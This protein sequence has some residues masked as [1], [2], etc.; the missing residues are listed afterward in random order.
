MLIS[1]I[2][3]QINLLEEFL[4]DFPHPNTTEQDQSIPLPLSTPQVDTSTPIVSSSPETVLPST[5]CQ[6]PFYQTASKTDSSLPF[7]STNTTEGSEIGLEY[8]QPSNI[9]NQIGCGGDSASNFDSA[10][11]ER[12]ERKIKSRGGKKSSTSSSALNCPYCN[13][14]FRYQRNY[15]K[16]VDLC[17]NKAACIYCAQV[18]KSEVKRNEHQSNCPAVTC[19][20]CGHISLSKDNHLHHVKAHDRVTF[21]CRTC[22][23][24]FYSKKELVKHQGLQHGWG[25]KK[26][27]FPWENEAPWLNEGGY[28]DKALEIAI[29]ASKSHILAP[30]SLGD[31][32]SIYNFPTNNLKG[33]MNEFSKEISEIYQDQKHSFRINIAFG[34]IIQNVE[35]GDYRYFIPYKNSTIFDYPMRVDNHKD[36]QKVKE[37]IG[38]IDLDDYF[39]TNRPNTKWKGVMIV[40]TTFFITKSNYV[41]GKGFLPD[42]IKRKKSITGLDSERGSRAPIKDKLCAFRCIA[43]FLGSQHVT[44]AAIKYYHKFREY[45]LNVLGKRISSNHSLFQGISMIDLPELERCFEICI[46]VYELQPDDTV[47]LRYKPSTNFSRVMHLNMYENHLSYINNFSS[48]AKKFSCPTCVRIFD[49]ISNYKSHLL[50]CGMRT[51]YKFKGGYYSPTLTIFE[52]LE[53]NGI[54]VPENM[55]LFEYF[56]VFDIESVLEKVDSGNAEKL[57]WA[58]RHSAISVSICSN[59]PGYDHPKC[60]I[61]PD[62]KKL[63]FKMLSYLDTVQLEVK[64]IHLERFEEYI[65]Q[66]EQ[67]RDKYLEE[68]MNESWFPKSPTLSNSSPQL[69]NEHLCECEGEDSGDESG[70][71]CDNN[72]ES[73]LEC[74]EQYTALDL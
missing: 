43:V 42:F 22:D 4:V 26:Q 41:L 69:F 14:E 74:D 68:Q 17:L 19:K 71:E 61:D 11:K 29:Q 27:E 7:P 48:Y 12:T 51:T 66:L 34:V 54:K 40:N 8:F 72:D 67:V 64:K 47:I 65:K 20:V 60:F 24:K 30:H 37:R 13:R 23:D 44:T 6:S 31:M 45:S 49:R 33:G 1:Q 46:Y 39:L 53:N 73:D 52:E 58:Q 35:N 25:D 38:T 63:T 50:K 9:A 59:V 62:L 32:V 70:G 56:A 5:S 55:R 28:H 3:F 36:I 18:F 57:K 15:D 21:T 16:H 10:R 2:Y